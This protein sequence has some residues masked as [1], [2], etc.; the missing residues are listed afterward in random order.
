[1][2]STQPSSKLS[3]VGQAIED[4]L[5]NQRSIGDISLDQFRK[6]FPAKYRDHA[7]VAEYYKAYQEERLARIEL[8]RSKVAAAFSAPEDHGFTMDASDPEVDDCMAMM[9]QLTERYVEEG[10]QYEARCEEALKVMTATEKTLDTLQ[11]VGNAAGNEEA[12]R[13]ISELRRS[14]AKAASHV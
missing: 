11:V 14:I 12:L 2:S 7:D 4:F 13:T 1:M 5:V 9:R 6:M 3:A 8:I 10:Q